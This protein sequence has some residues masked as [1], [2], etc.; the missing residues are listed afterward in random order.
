MKGSELIHRATQAQPEPN[1]GLAEAIKI[2]K[3]ENVRRSAFAVVI[4]YL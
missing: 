3:Y 2:K 4:L 1:R